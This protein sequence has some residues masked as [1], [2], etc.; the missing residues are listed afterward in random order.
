M[1]AART[2]IQCQE[3]PS[4]AGSE[5]KTLRAS[6][7]AVSIGF[8]S[9]V[10]GC[11]GSVDASN[12]VPPS[13]GR[14][15]SA[16]Q[17]PADPP[18]LAGVFLRNFIYTSGG[19]TARFGSSGDAVLLRRNDG[20]LWQLSVSTPE[21][22]RSDYPYS[23][24]L[25][26]GREDN[27]EFR[28]N[29]PNLEIQVPGS[30]YADFRI[31]YPQDG[32]LGRAYSVFETWDDPSRLSLSLTV[33]FGLHPSFTAVPLAELLGEWKALTSEREDHWLQLTVGPDGNFFLSDAVTGACQSAGVLRSRGNQLL[34]VEWRKPCDSAEVTAT[35]LA[36][37]SNSNLYGSGVSFY[38]AVTPRASPGGISFGL[39]A[40][41]RLPDY[42]CYD[43]PSA[44]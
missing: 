17:L 3:Q 16:V 7:I 28:W 21:G 42:L 25:V 44:C 14:L 37:L 20:Q 4:F 10:A 24:G 34:D 43:R 2:T 26:S 12:V 1:S 29:S 5:R 39:V 27:A 32:E 38:L 9:A 31:T 36:T 6:L 33:I 19:P 18:V 30:G 11:G 40:Q 35:G 13:A 8:L 15:P 41:R 22:P 23:V